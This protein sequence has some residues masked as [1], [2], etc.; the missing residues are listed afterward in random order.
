MA[1]ANNLLRSTS[2]FWMWD[3]ATWYVAYEPMA[4][5][6]AAPSNRAAKNLARSDRDAETKEDKFK[7]IKSNFG[8][9]RRK[10]DPQ[11]G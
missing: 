7:P 6:S 1:L 2:R 4:V 10:Q 9:Q 5:T 8:T 11:I 3:S